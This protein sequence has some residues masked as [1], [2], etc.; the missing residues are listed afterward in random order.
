MSGANTGIRQTISVPQNISSEPS[1]AWLHIFALQS[2]H[3]G[4]WIRNPTAMD[5]VEI[6][7]IGEWLNALVIPVNVNQ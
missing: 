2:P 7:E 1:T 5:K 3:V 4:A 6:F